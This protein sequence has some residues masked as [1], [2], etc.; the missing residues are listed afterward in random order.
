MDEMQLRTEVA[1]YVAIQRVGDSLLKTDPGSLF[2]LVGVGMLNLEPGGEG[3][4]R[5]TELLRSA[6]QLYPLEPE[7]YHALS[8]LALLEKRY[9][10]AAFLL[11]VALSL[12]PLYPSEIHYDLACAHARIGK[13]PAALAELRQSVR[14]GF[15]DVGHIKAD[16]DLESLRNDSGFKTFLEEEFPSAAAP[17]ATPKSLYSP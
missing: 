16:P 8:H 15:R 4:K 2:A 5:S 12:R 9:E 6:Q 1:G 17:K 10:D 7:V 13:K 3:A 11:Q 14:E